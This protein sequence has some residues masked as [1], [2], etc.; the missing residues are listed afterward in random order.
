[1]V[2]PLSFQQSAVSFQQNQKGSGYKAKGKF[3]EAIAHGL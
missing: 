3:P 1:M 2:P